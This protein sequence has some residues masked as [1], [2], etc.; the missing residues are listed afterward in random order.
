MVLS[1]NA[2]NG[3]ICMIVSFVGTAALF[4]LLEAYFLAILQVLV[5]AGAVMVLFLFIIML[6][7]V[8]KETN[9]YLKD[10]MTLAGSIMGFALLTILIFSTFVGDQHLPEAALPTVAE[11]PTGEGLGIPFTTSAKSFGYSLF[12]KY[13]LPFQVTGFLLLAAMVGVIVVSKKEED[14]K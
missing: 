11:N 9:H 7:D 14:A 1:P 8:D 12:T 13:M 6:L 4:V 10:K 3:A 5:Y 2:V